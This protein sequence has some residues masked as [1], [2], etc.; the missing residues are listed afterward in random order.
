[1][2]LYSGSQPDFTYDCVFLDALDTGAI[3]TSSKAV[4]SSEQIYGFEFTFSNGETLST[5]PYDV[6]RDDL[7][8]GLTRQEDD[9]WTLD[10]EGFSYIETYSNLQSSSFNMAGLSVYHNSIA[11]SV[12]NVTGSG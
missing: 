11:V 1:M 7:A 10:Q 6:S 12:G 8:P 4:F 5:Q 2:F 9:T 3:L